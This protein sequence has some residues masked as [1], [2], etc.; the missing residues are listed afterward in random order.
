MGHGLC[1][2]GLGCVEGNNVSVFSRNSAVSRN[3]P[4][5]ILE[6]AHVLY[7]PLNKPKNS[8]SRNTL[9]RKEGHADE[10]QD[11]EG[12]IERDEEEG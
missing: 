8:R 5:F 7:S 11:S 6:S 10:D 9:I 12:P 2:C 1:P 3:F 4:F